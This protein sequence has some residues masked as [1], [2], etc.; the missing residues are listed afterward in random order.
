MTEE[1]MKP[2]PWNIKAGKWLIKNFFN[3]SLKIFKSKQK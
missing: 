3:A 1:Q 2:L